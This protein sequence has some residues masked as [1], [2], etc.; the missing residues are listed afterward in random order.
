MPQIRVLSLP[1]RHPYT[2]KFDN[3]GVIR[4]VNPGTDYFSNP[5]SCHIQVLEAAHPPSTYDLVHIHFSFDHLTVNELR[6]LIRYFKRIHKPIVWT[7]HSREPQRYRSRVEIAP[8]QL[9]LYREADA[10]TTL[11]HGCAHWLERTLGKRPKPILIAPLGF[12]A[13]PERVAELKRGV[14]KMATRFIYLY[15]E[16]RANKELLVAVNA[17]LN[18]E[19]MRN[20][21]LLLL[22]RPQAQQKLNKLSEHSRL[23][24]VCRKSFS[25]DDLTRTF[26]SA[27]AV[28]IPYHWGTHSGQIELA[29]DCGCRVVISNV[30]FYQEQW[31][32]ITTWGS[33]TDYCDNFGLPFERAIVKV[34]QQKTLRPAGSIRRREFTKIYNQHV[35]L[36][37]SLLPPWG[38][39]VR[40]RE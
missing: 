34:A 3:E 13:P 37:C 5:R 40:L 18:C 38:Q 31:P 14:M 39:L 30:G 28:M 24:I 9:L 12:M 36:Y 6:R 23:K 20:C 11:T 15:G 35:A 1:A 4:F 27:H 10:V 25:N 17:F 32:A 19:A 16:G 26:L 8:R 29:R 33:Q 22:A 7:C 2:S 21:E